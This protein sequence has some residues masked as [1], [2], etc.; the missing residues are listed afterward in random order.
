MRIASF[1]EHYDDLIN[2]ILDSPFEEVNE[3]T[4]VKI[5]MIPGGSSF[6]IDLTNQRVAVTGTRKLYPHISAAECAWYLSGEKSADIMMRHNVKIWEKFMEPD[7]TVQGAYGYRF[8][9]AFGRDQIMLAAAALRKNPTDRRIWVQAWDPREDGLGAEG[10]RNVPCPVG[11]TFSIADG[12]L[13]SALFIRSSDVALGLPYD[14]MTHSMLMAAM[15]ASIG[16]MGV[17]TMHVTLAHPHIYEPQFEMVEAC[18]QQQVFPEGPQLLSWS[19]NGIRANP[20][21]Y[22]FAY[23]KMAQA[24]AWPAYNPKS[25]VVV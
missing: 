14:V 9:H 20:D 18:T 24:V 10:Q 6:K 13:H 21:G 17:G 3:R 23:R 7:G 25:E 1:Q 11:F 15:A 4:G 2:D 16:C 12:I 8:V 5:K 22:V 19:L